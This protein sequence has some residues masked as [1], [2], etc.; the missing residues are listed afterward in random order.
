MNEEKKPN[1]LIKTGRWLARPFRKAT[2]IGKLEQSIED[3]TDQLFHARNEN[4]MLKGDAEPD[5]K[6]VA[7]IRHLLGS[8]DLDDIELNDM[9]PDERKEY[10]GKATAA[11]QGTIKQEGKRLLKAQEEFVA[12]QA[13]PFNLLFARGTVNGITLFMEIYEDMQIE[14]RENNKQPEKFNAR[15]MFPE[16]GKQ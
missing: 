11:Y 3:L 7:L 5:K 8:V 12:R 15:A 13:E 9:A 10:V 16:L 6:A 14:H 4:A 2:H 1:I